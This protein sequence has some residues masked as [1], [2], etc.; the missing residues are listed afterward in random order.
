MATKRPF[1]NVESAG[2]AESGDVRRQRTSFQPPTRQPRMYR[3]S[4][5]GV[6]RFYARKIEKTEDG[7]SSGFYPDAFMPETFACSHNTN[8]PCLTPDQIG[9]SPD[10]FVCGIAYSPKTLDQEK[11]EHVRDFKSR[12]GVIYIN[13]VQ[14]GITGSVST[15]DIAPFRDAIVKMRDSVRDFY[16]SP[17][18]SVLDGCGDR[19]AFIEILRR[20]AQREAFEE[21]G[22]YGDSSVFE[23]VTTQNNFAIFK[24]N[25]S[26]LSKQPVEKCASFVKK[27]SDDFFLENKPGYSGRGRGLPFKI[28]LYI[29]GERAEFKK[30]IVGEVNFPSVGSE[31]D[32]AGVMV[33]SAADMEQF[34]CT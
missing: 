10:D 4:G 7:V 26:S 28:Q 18:Q 6:T 22:L 5:K 20:T 24:V 19:D 9:I 33:F 3:P 13:D 17:M 8:R 14:A 30:R 34:K 31:T 2:S 21:T 25:V 23:F 11:A 15:S 1:E 16:T 29:Y 27:T 32:I 12:D